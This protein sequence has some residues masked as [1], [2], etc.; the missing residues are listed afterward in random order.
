MEEATLIQLR[1][2]KEFDYKLNTY[3]LELKREGVN[4]SKATLIMELAEQMLLKRTVKREVKWILS[5][6]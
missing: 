4:K 3:L 6:K 2:P 1:L 5:A